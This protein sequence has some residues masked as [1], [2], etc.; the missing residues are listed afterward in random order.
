M[1]TPVDYE[2][3]DLPAQQ[4]ASTILYVLEQTLAVAGIA[5]AKTDARCLL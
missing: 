1:V 5:S 2:K 3:T 4:E